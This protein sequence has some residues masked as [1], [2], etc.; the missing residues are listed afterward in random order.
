MLSKRLMLFVATIYLGG[1][2]HTGNIKGTETLVAL[3]EN[4]MRAYQAGDEAAWA[5][6]VCGAESANALLIGWN[7]MRYFVGDISNIRAVSL[8]APSSAGNSD[9][10]FAIPMATYQVTSSNYPLTELLLKFYIGERKDCV[11]LTY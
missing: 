11:G 7:K 5:R 8:T 6:L 2:S 9:R 4:A 3:S 1:C 10:R